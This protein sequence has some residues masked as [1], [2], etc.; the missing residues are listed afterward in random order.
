MPKKQEV[1]CKMWC[2][3]WEKIPYC[4]HEH[5]WIQNTANCCEW[6]LKYVR[7]KKINKG[8]LIDRIR[9]EVFFKFYKNRTIFLIRIGKKSHLLYVYRNYC[10]FKI[11]QIGIFKAKWEIQW[12][13]HF[14]Q[15]H[16]NIYFSQKDDFFIQIDG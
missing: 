8:V 10:M 14:S 9:R 2:S 5:P 15:F 1:M 16:V 12:M 13:I 3:L 11:N 7:T 6:E 4:K